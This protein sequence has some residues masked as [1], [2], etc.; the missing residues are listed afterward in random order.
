MVENT[1]TLAIF[2][3]RRSR[4]KVFALLAELNTS[5]RVVGVRPL[6]RKKTAHSV[7]A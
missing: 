5:V 1:D 3:T 4:L 7:D 6:E 2:A